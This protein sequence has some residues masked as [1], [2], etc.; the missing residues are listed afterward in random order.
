MSSK[1]QRTAA[2]SSVAVCRLKLYVVGQ[3]PKSLQAFANLTKICDEYF[4]DSYQIEVIDLAKY[5]QRAQGD[6]IIAIPTV[7][8]DLPLPTRKIIGDMSN[9]E[10]VLAGLDLRACGGPLPRE[11]R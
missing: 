9:L 6:Q 7:V 4:A 2:R 5:P 1:S 11:T 8:R 10:R 3:A